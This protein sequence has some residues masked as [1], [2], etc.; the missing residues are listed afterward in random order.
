[1][2]ITVST[3]KARRKSNTNFDIQIVLDK[4]VIRLKKGDLLGRGAGK[5]VLI[6]LCFFILPD[7]TH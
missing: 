6:E 3:P 5:A 1:M 2:L 7:K 4:L